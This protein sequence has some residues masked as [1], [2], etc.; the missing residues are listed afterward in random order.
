MDHSP[1]SAQPRRQRESAVLI[2]LYERDDAVQLLFIKRTERVGTHKGEI[3]FPGGRIETDDAS[4]LAAALREA[5]EE[6]GIPVADVAPLGALPSVDTIVT[7]MLIYPFIGRLDAPPTLIPSPFEVAETIEVPLPHLLDPATYHEEEWIIR[8]VKRPIF[9]Y[10]YGPYDIWGATGRI[11]QLFLARL[12]AWDD[13]PPHT[14][15]TLD[16]VA[17]ALDATA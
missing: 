11:V 9:F 13:R 8:G 10:R 16:D 6:V 3:G 7:G 2:A 14:A 5:E 17:A 12:E 1:P 15:W 4:P